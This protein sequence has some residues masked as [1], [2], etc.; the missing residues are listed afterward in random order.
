MMYKD[1]LGRLFKVVWHY[2]GRLKGGWRA[3]YKKPES[4]AW[5]VVVILP[6][7]W[8]REAAEKELAG[9]AARHDMQVVEG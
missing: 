9:Y 8:G 6:D 3:Y 5:R 2:E 4:S 1:K 7:C